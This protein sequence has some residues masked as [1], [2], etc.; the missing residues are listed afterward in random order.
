VYHANAPSS[1][2]L[3]IEIPLASEMENGILFLGSTATQRD[4][5]CT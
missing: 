5:E 4:R 2:I 3:G 1:G